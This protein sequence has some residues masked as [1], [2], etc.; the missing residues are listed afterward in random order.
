[1]RSGARV[2]DRMP[3]LLAEQDFEPCAER[4]RWRRTVEVGPRRHGANAGRCRSASIA[5]TPAEDPTPIQGLFGIAY[6]CEKP[7]LAALSSGQSNSNGHAYEHWASTRRIRRTASREVGGKKPSPPTATGP[8]LSPG[9]QFTRNLSP[10]R[11]FDPFRLPG[12]AFLQT[13]GAQIGRELDLVCGG[14]HA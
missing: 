10:G 5:R 4:H 3:A 14:L 2:H 9:C 6:F 7:F 8:R 11:H 13:V 1:M 12:D